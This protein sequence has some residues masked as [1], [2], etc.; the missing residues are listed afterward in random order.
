MSERL[1]PFEGGV[2]IKY[3]C[4][5]GLR[6]D[7][8]LIRP[9]GM[10]QQEYVDYKSRSHESCNSCSFKISYWCGT[11]NSEFEFA[12]AESWA[13]KVAEELIASDASCA[14]NIVEVIK[15]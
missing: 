5:F 11:M 8:K 4:R 6:A 15:R 10:G 3:T 13:T 2:S 9:E 12:R 7:I 1:G 14:V